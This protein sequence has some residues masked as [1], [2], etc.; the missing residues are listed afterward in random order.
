MK[1]NRK[2]LELYALGIFLLLAPVVLVADQ[3]LDEKIIIKTI[4]AKNISNDE[5]GNLILEEDVIIITNLLEF[6]TDKAIYN[7]TEGTL[8][9]K[10]RTEI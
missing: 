2:I 10:A 7:Q 5:K 4:D 1:T 6:R 8:E 3:L 9:L